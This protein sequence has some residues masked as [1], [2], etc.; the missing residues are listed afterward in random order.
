MPQEAQTEFRK[1]T[2]CSLH[3]L[4]MQGKPALMVRFRECFLR[5]RNHVEFTRLLKQNDIYIDICQE[6]HRK[7]CIDLVTLEFAGRNSMRRSLGLRGEDC[8]SDA[9]KYVND[10]IGSGMAIIIQ[11][12]KYKSKYNPNYK[13]IIGINISCDICDMAALNDHINNEEKQKRKL[14]SL[15]DHGQ[16]DATVAHLMCKYLLNTYQYHS[17]DL[18]KMFLHSANIDNYRRQDG[19]KN[20]DDN[21]EKNRY[22]YKLKYNKAVFYSVGTIDSEYSGQN[23][24]KLFNLSLTLCLLCAMKYK[25]IWFGASNPITVYVT[26]K[27]INWFKKNNYNGFCN[28]RKVWDYK[29]DPVFKDYMFTKFGK[30]NAMI[31]MQKYGTKMCGCYL[32]ITN[33]HSQLTVFDYFKLFAKSLGVNIATQNEISID[34]KL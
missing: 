26:T 1:I 9:I 6:I 14:I 23:F 2:N 31:K 27:M 29:N 32:D 28:E 16:T 34:S 12:A 20:G 24:G 19:Y 15:I 5:L 30:E 33:M 18:Y 22:K 11:D 13:K 7:E 10:A 17:D 3:C 8:I 21:C 4:N 25:Y